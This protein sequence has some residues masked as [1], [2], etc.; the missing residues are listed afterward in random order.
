MRE[1]SGE[2]LFRNL[3][4]FMLESRVEG[5]QLLDGHSHRNIP[6]RVLPSSLTR[7]SKR[8]DGYR[9]LAKAIILTL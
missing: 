8:P 7:V 9:L 2:Q 3:R 5:L 6:R 4:V 1:T